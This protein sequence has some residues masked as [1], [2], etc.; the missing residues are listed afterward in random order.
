M[1]EA[2]LLFRECIERLH[3]EIDS[4]SKCLEVIP[5]GTLNE[6]EVLELE[7]SLYHLGI[8]QEHLVTLLLARQHDYAAK[9]LYKSSI[10]PFY[11]PFEVY[12]A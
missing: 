4:V 2:A 1:D 5:V 8:S 9:E 3:R 7:Q 11:F 10:K 6:T 12:S